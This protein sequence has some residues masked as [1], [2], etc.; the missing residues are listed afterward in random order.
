MS[1]TVEME[2]RNAAF[3]GADDDYGAGPEVARILREIADRLDN[4]G[5]DALQGACVDF[6]GNR[7]GNWEL[8]SE[9]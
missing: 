2:T 7:V 8:V 9:R 5:T 6:N 1:F 3:T 4:V